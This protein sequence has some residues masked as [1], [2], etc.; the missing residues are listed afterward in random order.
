MAFSLGIA[1]RG[2][3]FTPLQGFLSS[4]ITYASAGQYMG[5]SLYAVNGTIFQLIILTV[6]INLRYILMGFAL[7]QRMP[8]GTALFKRVLVGSCITDEIFGATISRS[9]PPTPAYTLGALFTAVP[10]WA[11]GTGMGISMGNILPSRIVSALGVALFG[12]FLA[13][14][15]PASKKDKGILLAV[16][17]S[18]AASY[19]ATTVPGI[20]NL[21][22]GTRTILLTITIS[23]LFAI[24]VPAKEESNRA[25]EEDIAGGEI[26]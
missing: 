21:S 23:A 9:A 18:F 26:K 7:N 10:M 24:L 3:G 13:T 11:L 8:A 17:V 19:A 16:I 25:N 22:E 2:Y 15:V 6:I 20:S 1:A 4:L 14:I 12:M 5:F